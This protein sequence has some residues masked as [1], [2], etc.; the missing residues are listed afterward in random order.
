MSPDDDVPTNPASNIVV[1]VLMGVL[2]L[3]LISVLLVYLRARSKV[4]QPLDF[5]KQL[6]DLIS[7]GVITDS[8]RPREIKRGFITEMEEL[9]S[10]AFGTVTKGW[11]DESAR[12]HVPAF[13]VAL[14]KLRS[15]GDTNQKEAFLREASIMAQLQHENVIGLIGVVTA[16]EPLI[17]VLQ[18][19]NL[20]SLDN[21]LRARTGISEISLAA[22]L[23]ICQNIAAG[24]AY[25]CEEKNLVHR[26]L[27]ARNVL[28]TADSTPKISDFGFTR[29]VG[30]SK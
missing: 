11:L 13:A 12:T 30:E 26:D 21:F 25:L 22:R 4:N 27:A 28:L 16:G 10:G 24:M 19:A 18:F 23:Q 14:K 1:S 5:D 3:V 8:Q 9:G 2:L 6:S 7:A 15:A 20:G 17:I 29:E